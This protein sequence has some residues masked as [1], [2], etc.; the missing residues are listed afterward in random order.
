MQA[1]VEKNG[2]R[3][4]T[5]ARIIVMIATVL[6]C[7]GIGAAQV[8]TG[9]VAGTV[10]DS[11]GAIIPNASITVKD[12]DTGATRNATSGPQGGYTVP[13]LLPGNYEV[14]IA[15]GNFSPYK[16]EVQ[17]TV[18]G[19]STVD[20]TL[21][22][23][24]ATTTVEVVGQEAGVEVNTQTQEVS[25]I[26]TPAEVANLPSLTRNPY[27]FVGIAG[28]VSGG[29]RAM[30]SSNPQLVGSGQNSTD[31]GVGYSINGQRASGTELLLDGVENTNIFDTTIALWIPQDAVQE[32]R[33]V[34]NNFEPQYGRAAGGVVNVTSKSG[35]NAFHGSG[36]DFNRLSAYTAN[37]FDN[38]AHGIPKG[39]YTRNEF[40]YTFGGPVIK[41]KLFF[42][43]STE[44]LRVRSNTILQ[45]YVPTPQFLALTPSNV[46]AYFTQYGTPAPTYTTT[47]PASALPITLPPGTPASTPVFGLAQFT[48]PADAGGDLPQ[49]TYTLAGRADYNM[50]DRTQMFFRFGRESL[51]AFKGTAFA[52]PYPQ[53][54][55]GTTIYNNSFLYSISHSFSPN[56]LS[57]TRLSFFRDSVA[58]P[59][60]TALTN[61]PTL[62]LYNGATL[63]GQP[64]S[65]PGFFDVSTGTG[66][67]PF[68]GPQN[69]AQFNEDLAWTHRNHTM[70]FGGQFNYVQLNRAFGAYAQGNEQFGANISQ[71]L[72][73]FLT[74]TLTNF[75]VAINPHGAFPCQADPAVPDPTMAG[76]LIETPQCLVSLPTTSP[77]FARSDRYRDWA[78]Y[79]QDSWKLTPRLT[80]NYGVRYEYYGVQHN[81]NQNLDSNFYYG[82]GSSYFDQVRN[83]S[84][85]IAPASSVGGLWNPRYGTIGPRVGFAYD[86]FGN[87]STALR[88]GWGISYERN[89]GNVT[90][91]VIQNPPAYATPQARGVALTTDNLGPFAASSGSVALFPSSPRNVDQ[92][93]QVAQTQFYSLSLERRLGAGAVL[94]VEY[95]GA[96]G[97]HLYDVKNINELGGGQA[98]LGDPTNDSAACEAFYGVASPSNPSVGPCFT[99]PNQQWT[100][101][102]NRGT[103]GFSHYNGLNIRFQ[104]QNI[105]RTGLTIVTN[106]T[107][108][109]SLD[110][111]SSTFAENSSGS[112]GVGNLG[113]LD[114]RDPALDYGSSDFDIRHRVAFSAVWTEPFFRGRRDAFG[115]VA[116]GWV[117]SPI[118]TA[119]TGVP[120]SIA[121]SSFSLNAGTG[122]GIPR[123]AP[124]SPISTFRVGSGVGAGQNDFT[125]LT[126]PDANSF[127]GPLGVSD[128]GPYP[129]DMTTRNAFRGPGAWN[130]DLAVSKN[131]KLTERLSLQFRAEGF[132]LFNHHDMFVNGFAEDAAAFAG[133]PVL[134]EGKKGGLGSLAT[135]GE[136]DERRF[137]QFA[138]RFTF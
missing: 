89:F 135:G 81:A 35:T 90:Y 51:D 120:F 129:S 56:V 118:F 75:Q 106:Y 63:N 38:V 18:G 60:N 105:H 98:Y 26:V 29:D 61:T 128:F 42:F 57:N 16:R 45:G 76:H 79:A 4:Q 84:V 117:V 23:G 114:P 11:T 64:I 95:N 66:G 108:S 70:R 100:S 102:N 10:R 1:D 21:G 123:Y 5:H 59:Y 41:D 113:Y 104:T 126:L 99:R 30:S 83:G 127:V 25:Q 72:A 119:R 47:V 46:Q 28:N 3:T 48:A 53:Y 37:T 33:V 131:F 87:G 54:N 31:R 91:N 82:P 7:C 9:T 121:D 52:S 6:L 111:L 107:Y 15:S 138:L 137:G 122:T 109:H 71:G 132:N 20:G 12:L 2:S 133:G 103:S 40:G 86:L 130:F 27:D 134:V 136:H 77:G 67:L 69:S 58:E 93:I 124:S 50:S 74:G 78:L 43:Q 19:I 55:V 34:T 88:G 96:H 8:Q 80:L 116:G 94:A 36:W 85:Q 24:T 97:V 68:G 44:W 73:N 115:Q 13:G 101:I 22:L 14:A 17:V 49:N 62:Y 125:L 110:N 92:N 112:S 65:L 32:F 39:T